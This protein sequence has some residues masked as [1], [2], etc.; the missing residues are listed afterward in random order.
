MQRAGLGLAALVSVTGFALLVWRHVVQGRRSEHSRRGRSSVVERQ[1]PKLN[2][3]GSIPI[4]RSNPILPA[5][6]TIPALESL[7]IRRP[8]C[9]ARRARS[10]SFIAKSV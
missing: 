1:L 2:V 9:A 8:S 6:A 4:A 7:L 5:A 3:V 10:S